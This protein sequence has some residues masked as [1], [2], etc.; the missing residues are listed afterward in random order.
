MLMYNLI[1]YFENYTTKTVSS[2]Q[3]HKDVASGPIKNYESTT[4]KVKITG[5]IPA[6][7]NTKDGE[8]AGL[9]KD[10]IDFCQNYLN[11]FD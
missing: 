4:F 9:L 2:W 8:I 11:D 3:Y 5:S 1:E 6:D 10:L 7:G